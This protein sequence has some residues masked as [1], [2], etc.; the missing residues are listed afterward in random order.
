MFFA[1]QYFFGPN[2]DLLSE[3]KMATA[4]GRLEDMA[5]VAASL[6]NK[7]F[8]VSESKYGV[9]GAGASSQIVSSMVPGKLFYCGGTHDFLK[10]EF[11]AKLR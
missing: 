9:H 10:K 1:G 2:S 3:D 11:R 4:V 7:P 8:S 5:K 6:A